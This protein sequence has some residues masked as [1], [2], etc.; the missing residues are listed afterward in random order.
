MFLFKNMFGW[1]LFHFVDSLMVSSIFK[2]F[3]LPRFRLYP[4]W[5]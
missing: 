3:C 5:W 4:A 2:L 1:I